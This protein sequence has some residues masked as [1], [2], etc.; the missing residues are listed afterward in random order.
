MITPF[1]AALAAAEAMLAA[2]RTD[3][4]VIVVGV[5]RFEESV[6]KPLREV[7]A[8]PDDRRESVIQISLPEHLTED[9]V[10]RILVDVLR[11]QNRINRS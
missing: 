10:R 5:E 9:E 7:A 2:G 4:D 1:G 6:V 8:A 11:E 3:P